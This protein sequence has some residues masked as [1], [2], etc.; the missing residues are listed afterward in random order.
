MDSLL[1]KPISRRKIIYTIGA[2]SSFPLLN[3]CASTIQTTKSADLNSKIKSLVIW[4]TGGLSEEY[5]T[6]LDRMESTATALQQNFN[7]SQVTSKIL[8]SK[9]MD[10]DKQAR[11]IQASSD[12]AADH[13]LSLTVVK[14]SKR[15]GSIAVEFFD[16]DA[17]L[18]QIS[19]KRMLWKAQVS[20]NFYS[21][22]ASMAND[23]YSRLK[24]D[25]VIA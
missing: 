21:Q 6:L 20:A 2:M 8:T 24:Q 5:S 7:Q 16:Y 4:N 3:G 12:I 11:L 25:G 1:S 23:L 15:N 14:A 13:V 9:R 10:Q 22:S 18:T 17:V 19:N